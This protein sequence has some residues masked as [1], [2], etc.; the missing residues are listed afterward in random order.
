MNQ[1]LIRPINGEE[2]TIEA[3]DYAGMM[4]GA[5]ELI[6]VG[7]ITLI[8]FYQSSIFMKTKIDRMTLI[9]CLD[10]LGYFDDQDDDECDCCC[11][12]EAESE[13]IQKIDLGNIIMTVSIKEKK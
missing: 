5:A 13:K 7:E 11:D 6:N 1:Y 2:Y 9:N 12:E 8:D 3:H 4:R 10:D